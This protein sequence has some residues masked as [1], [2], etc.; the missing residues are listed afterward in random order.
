MG[1]DERKLRLNDGSEGRHEDGSTLVRSLSYEE[2]ISIR[3]SSTDAVDVVLWAHNPGITVSVGRVPADR[4]A[5]LRESECTRQSRHPRPRMTHEKTSLPT[6]Q[7]IQHTTASTRMRIVAP[8]RHSA[9]TTYLE[10]SMGTRIK[11]ISGGKASI[12]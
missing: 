4:A 2:R 7:P 10:G 1:V 5:H 11:G 12:W 8:G 9:R 6:T 3:I